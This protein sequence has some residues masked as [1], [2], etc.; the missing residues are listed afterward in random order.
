MQRLA[1][2]C[3]S[4]DEVSLRTQSHPSLH[5]SEIIS[6]RFNVPETIARRILGSLF[7]N[8][9]ENRLR[10]RE[11]CAKDGVR[12][13]RFFLKALALKRPKVC[14]LLFRDY[15][16]EENLDRRN[17]LRIS[18]LFQFSQKLILLQRTSTAQKVQKWVFQFFR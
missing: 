5:S 7:C 18:L 1:Q 17:V 10:S 14:E 8:G 16:K 13:S 6:S 11:A 3:L 12:A 15:A 2:T 4:Y 9:V